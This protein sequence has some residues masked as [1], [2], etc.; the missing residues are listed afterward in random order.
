MA[1]V[2]L[3][4]AL[5]IP[6][7]AEDKEP[8]Y[9]LWTSEIP[10]DIRK[11]LTHCV[12]DFVDVKASTKVFPAVQ[13]MHQ[14]VRE[15]FLHPSNLVQK[16][17]L[18]V[19][20]HNASEMIQLTCIRFL[21]IVYKEVSG[22][23][24]PRPSGISAAQMCRHIEYLEKRPFI[25]FSLEY[26]EA[27]LDALAPD[28]TSRLSILLEKTEISLRSR[29]LI[30]MLLNQLLL[31]NNIKSGVDVKNHTDRLILY[32]AEKGY[33][34][35]IRN[36]LAISATTNVQNNRQETLLHVAVRG[37]HDEATNLVI[38]SGAYLEAQDIEGRTALHHAVLGEHEAIIQTL[39]TNNAKTDARD[40]TGQNAVH[41]A[42]INRLQDSLRVLLI[43][44]ADIEELNREGFN[45]LHLAVMD[46]Q[47]SIVQLLLGNN[48]NLKALDA[49]GRNA[50][51]LAVRCQDEAIVRL[52]LTHNAHPDA[53]GSD[54][55]TA[56]HL[57]V[58]DNHAAIAQFLLTHNANP[59]AKN[60]MR[61]TTLHL[62]VIYEREAI[63]QLLLTHD[64]DPQ[65]R[66]LDDVS[67]T[68]LA[69]MI[70][71]DSPVFE[72]LPA[73]VD[74]DAMLL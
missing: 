8:N 52:L 11:M 61:Q 6:G 1:L 2:D 33:P 32:A 44:K 40:K 10:G 42:V 55:Q 48:V 43:N 12:G 54:G 59:Q 70:E 46:G 20:E 4:H 31:L 68:E 7:L 25:K 71:I 17:H 35:A 29:S 16:S 30:T 24:I 39:L 72:P 23:T 67:A 27:N 56:L 51:H 37:G 73:K 19:T 26:L 28:I 13:V 38:D 58:L 53:Q 3:K 63:V 41:L 49:S 9:K 36:L 66:N 57:A 62:A 60:S 21:E 34:T 50:L 65:E 74:D 69:S 64:A 47:K 18:N 5:G 45:A 22:F 14:T 15:F